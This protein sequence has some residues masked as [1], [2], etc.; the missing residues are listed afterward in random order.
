MVSGCEWSDVSLEGEWEI[1]FE[2]PVIL[3]GC[4]T[5]AHSHCTHC[6]YLL[7]FV[8]AVPLSKQISV[9]RHVNTSGFSHGL[10]LTL[11]HTNMCIQASTL[12]QT[13]TPLTFSTSS[14]LDSTMLP[15]DSLTCKRP[16]TSELKCL[17]T[18]LF[19]A[20]SDFHSQK[21]LFSVTDAEDSDF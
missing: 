13:S 1:L 10:I 6:L 17:M 2:T 16:L 19:S 21:Q 14:V 9:N 12:T 8:M 4:F 11:S 20:K 18:C 7:G 15:I 3:W 5:K